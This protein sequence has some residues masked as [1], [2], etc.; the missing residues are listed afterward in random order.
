RGGSRVD[1]AERRRRRMRQIGDD[2]GT[3]GDA[4]P[5]WSP[6]TEPS[7]TSRSSASRSSRATRVLRAAGWV[8]LAAV[9]VVLVAAA[10]VRV[11]DIIIR[12]GSATPLDARVVKVDGAPTYPH[13]GG[14]LFL[15][16]QV[17]NRDPNVYRWLFAKL[18]NDVDVEKRAAYISGCS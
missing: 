11:P 16:V 7:G 10:F 12:P 18:D 6:P 8:A 15:T 13:R 14:F 17:N 5:A 4:V 9:V 3:T 1:A 2:T